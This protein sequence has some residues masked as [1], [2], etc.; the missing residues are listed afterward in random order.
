MT[1]V[2]TGELLVDFPLAGGEMY[3]DEELELVESAPPGW[4]PPSTAT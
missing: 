2:S 4:K 1:R 3:L